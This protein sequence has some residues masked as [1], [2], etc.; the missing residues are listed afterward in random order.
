M[1]DLFYLKGRIT[2]WKGEVREREREKEILSI[3]WF[4]PKMVGHRWVKPKPGTQNSICVFHLGDRGPR[5]CVIFCCLPEVHLQAAGQEVEQSGLQWSSQDSS[6]Y[7]NMLLKS[8]VFS[9]LCCFPGN[10]MFICVDI[11]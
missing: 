7:S 9:P 6:G 8:Q 11:A 2:E 10:Q 4:T 1:I 5:T 3:H